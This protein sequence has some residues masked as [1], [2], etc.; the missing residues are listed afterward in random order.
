MRFALVRTT[1][2]DYPGRVA[3][4]VFLPGCHLRCPYCHNPEFVDP[5]IDPGAAAL[6]E[7]IDG[8]RAFL[9]RRARL[10]GGIVFSGG[11]ALLHP[12]LPTLIEMVEEYKLPIKLDTAG[13]LPDSLF[14]YLEKGRLNYVSVDLKTVP[15]RYSE[16]GWRGSGDNSAEVLLN[17]TISMLG[18]SDIPWELR[19]TVVPPLVNEKILGE[20]AVIAATAPKWIWQPYRGGNTLDPAWSSLSAPDEEQLIE[21]SKRIESV[22]EIVVR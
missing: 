6:N 4:S 2:L 20:L 22:S 3:A 14:P 12:L 19:T 5:A 18:N 17:R 10:L 7:D 9:A 8:F 13:L 11:E 1:L 15:E 16:L 21:M